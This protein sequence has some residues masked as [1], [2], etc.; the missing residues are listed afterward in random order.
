M[1]TRAHVKG[2][3]T[4]AALFVSTEMSGVQCAGIRFHH[5]G[6]GRI[7]KR[8]DIDARRGEPG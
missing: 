3:A 8:A 5:P 7:I 2:G 6:C 1:L 4:G